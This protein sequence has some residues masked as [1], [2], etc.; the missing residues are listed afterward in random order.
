MI[1]FT[2]KTYNSKSEIQDHQI[3]ILNKGNNSGKVLTEPCPNCFVITAKSHLEIDILKMI[4]YRA[5]VNKLFYRELIGS[6]IP[7]VRIN[8]AKRII[9]Y[10][11][12]AYSRD[13]EKFIQISNQL[14]NVEKALAHY[15]LLV[16]KLNLM[17]YSLAKM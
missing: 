3:F 1:E 6:V 7:F 5:L 14:Q 15:K 11:L 2:I 4:C 10:G 9:Q 17:R 13:P 12:Q 16:D 8:D